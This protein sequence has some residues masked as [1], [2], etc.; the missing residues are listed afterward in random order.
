MVARRICLHRLGERSRCHAFNWCRRRRRLWTRR[1]GR[2]WTPAKLWWICIT[3]A[4]SITGSIAAAMRVRRHHQCEH[5]RERW[6]GEREREWSWLV[7]LTRADHVVLTGFVQMAPSSGPLGHVSVFG[8]HL[9]ETRSN[10]AN[11]AISAFCKNFTRDAVIFATE[12]RLDGFLQ[13]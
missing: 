13:S 5:A 8:P 4:K 12:Y 11:R 1:L 3:T 6:E 9:S 2:V 7:C 10:A